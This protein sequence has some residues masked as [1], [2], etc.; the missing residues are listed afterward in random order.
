[1]ETKGYYAAVGFFVIVLSAIGIVIGLWLSVG[2]STKSYDNYTIYMEE[3]VA[4]LSVSAPVKYNGVDMGTVKKISVDPMDP[5]RVIIIIAI[6]PQAPINTATRAI[7]K[8]QGL[9]GVAYMEL[10]GSDPNA[11][12]LTVQPGQQ[13]PVIQ[14]TPSLLFRIDVAFETL[15]EN[16][17]KVT[18]SLG[19]VF[20][21][22]NGQLLTDTLENINSASRRLNDAAG[23][24]QFT[25]Q[26]SNVTLET[27][28]SQTLP[29][30]T[31]LLEDVDGVTL[32]LNDF[33]QQLSDNPSMLVRGQK[34]APL[35]PGET[36]NTTKARN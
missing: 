21:E 3:S 13:Y 22:K 14:S 34:A 15:S 7:L 19:D 33:I 25:I 30:M 28:N 16:L 8:M 35:G 4:G 9:T 10:S 23:S 32:R 11:P 36:G 5:Q 31:N 18:N 29:Q 26:R 2:V 24:A 27:I 20:N 17:E 12:P 1:M 6:D